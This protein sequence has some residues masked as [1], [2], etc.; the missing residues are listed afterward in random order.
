MSR[1]K[2]L[3][4]GNGD[5]FYIDHNSDNF[6]IIDCCY[7]SDEAFEEDIEEIKKSASQKGIIRFISTHPDEDHIRG[8]EK[9]F[10]SIS[11]PNFYVVKNNATKE[12]ESDSFNYYCKLRDRKNT[13]YV[14]KNCTRKWMNVKDEERGSSGINFE[15]PDTE[16]FEFKEVLKRVKKGEQPNNLSPIFTYSLNN[17]VKVMWMGDIESDF[18]EKVKDGIDWPQIDILFAPHHGRDSGKPSEDILKK[19]NPKLVVIGEAQSKHLNYYSGYHTITQNS[20]KDIL[21]ICDVGVVDIYVGSST[22]RTTDSFLVNK[23]KSDMDGL[24][25]LGTLEL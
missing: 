6:T 20:A 18:L 2:S 19:L 17:G 4:V 12:E 3:S 15:W 8:I 24:S 9:L 13:F 5:M 1:I 11:I 22:Y 10:E 16:N 25:Y 14:Y 23:K 21:F 7:E